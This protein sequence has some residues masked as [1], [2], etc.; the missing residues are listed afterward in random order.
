MREE[1]E[2]LRR[3]IR[4]ALDEGCQVDHEAVMAISRAITAD[5]GSIPRHEA[6]EVIRLVD[7]I[8]DDLREGQGAVRQS[9]KGTRRGRTA[10]RGYSNLRSS[11]TAQRIRR[12][13]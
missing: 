3:S 2:Q 6:A 7:A 10:L 13:G 9:L 8:T 12:K 11:A 1:L 5:P 4:A